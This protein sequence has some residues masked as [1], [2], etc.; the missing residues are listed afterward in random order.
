M[1][2][3][4][5]WRSTT[6]GKLSTSRSFWLTQ[7]LTLI[8][9]LLRVLLV[10][11]NTSIRTKICCSNC[12][13]DLGGTGLMPKNSLNGK[14]ALHCIAERPDLLKSVETLKLLLEHGAC[15]KEKDF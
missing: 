14:T 9:P 7:T 15:P 3:R 6:I 5:R 8:L 13:E 2:M 1:R 12:A 4:R 11:F 10:N